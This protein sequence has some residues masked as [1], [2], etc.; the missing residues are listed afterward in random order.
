MHRLLFALAFVIASFTTSAQGIIPFVGGN[1]SGYQLKQ[2]DWASSGLPGLNVGAVA[3]GKLFSR[4]SW[5]AGLQYSQL[6]GK[7]TYTYLGS[8][9]PPSRYPYT[10]RYQYR[11]HAVQLPVMLVLKT[12]DEDHERFFAGIGFYV[13][14][15]MGGTLN[16][17]TT[18]VDPSGHS[19]QHT[20]KENLRF[21]IADMNPNYIKRFDFG[22]NF[23]VGYHMAVGPELYLFYQKGV[24]DMQP[25]GLAG[26][27]TTY[28]LGIAVRY[29][30]KW[31]PKQTHSKKH[32][33]HN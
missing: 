14:E 27:S 13:T 26:K 7:L 28:Q 20:V 30:L 2:D 21:D 12:G 25:G 18:V 10:S 29:A 8:V 16:A 24:V 32:A 1:L 6:G 23:G 5:Q 33:N 22:L 4:F 19:T 17:E 15:N 11:V 31:S 3:D 9:A